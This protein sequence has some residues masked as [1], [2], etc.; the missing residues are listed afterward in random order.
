VEDKDAEEKEEWDM[1]E[2]VGMVERYFYL[3]CKA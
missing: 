2:M 3:Q 1:V